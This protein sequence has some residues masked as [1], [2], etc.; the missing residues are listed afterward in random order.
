M[1]HHCHCGLGEKLK[2]LRAGKLGLL[3]GVLVVGHLLFHVAECLVLPAFI[4]ALHGNAAEATELEETELI[5]T[6]LKNDY[7]PSLYID[8]YDSLYEYDILSLRKRF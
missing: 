4:M 2:K 1:K 7:R 6:N 8:F 3:G 5:E